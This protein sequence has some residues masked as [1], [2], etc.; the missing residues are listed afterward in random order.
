MAPQPIYPFEPSYHALPVLI[1]RF[2]EPTNSTT[3]KSH[4]QIYAI[5]Y[6]VLGA[7]S[8]LLT[9]HVILCHLFGRRPLL[10]WQVLE[11][12][13]WN[14]TVVTLS[15]LVSV[16]LSSVT[17]A[18]TRGSQALMVLAGMQIVLGVLIDAI[19]IHRLMV[20]S[21]GWSNGMGAWGIPMV[22]TGVFSV[23]AFYQ[24]PHRDEDGRTGTILKSITFLVLLALLGLSG[25]AT[26]VTFLGA[27]FTLFRE[28]RYFA[29]SAVVLTCALFWL[30]DFAIALVNKNTIGTPSQRIAPMYYAFWVVERMP[31]F[32]F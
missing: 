26:L 15:S 16:I 6:G 11:K 21:E 30:G 20:K 31:L 32:T 19:H 29:M 13:V 5:P 10:P 1:P 25:F 3:F 18:R 14:I 23:W 24:F 4:I 27:V 12:T 8:H 2:L 7:V 22:I 17:L 9:F 28:S